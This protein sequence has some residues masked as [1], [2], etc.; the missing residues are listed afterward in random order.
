MTGN[1]YQSLAARTIDWE[2]NEVQIEHHALHGMVGELGELH[3]TY[4][5]I[6]Q[7]HGINEEHQKKECG[8]IL[9]FLAEYCTAKGWKLEDVMQTNIEKLIDRYPNGFEAAKSLHRK[10][11]DI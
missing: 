10:E 2:L 3:S 11:G 9:W 6:Y 1:E 5:K 7:G 8:D 4:Q